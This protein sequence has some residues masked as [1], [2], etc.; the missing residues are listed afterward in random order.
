[1]NLFP[2]TLSSSNT[3]P[4][5]P[6]LPPLAPPNPSEANLIQRLFLQATDP[7]IPKEQRNRSFSELLDSCFPQN[8]NSALL[9]KIR[10]ASG[11]TLVTFAI[12]AKENEWTSRLIRY[13]S[14]CLEKDSQGNT[15][16]HQAAIRG[17]SSL[18]L[19]L[20]RINGLAEPNEQGET[21]LHLAIKHGHTEIILSLMEQ[22]LLPAE[23]LFLTEEYALN[24]L[25]Y[26]AFLGQTEIFAH[27]LTSSLFAK[28][29]WTQGLGNPLHVA[30]F[31]N[32]IHFPAYLQRQHPLLFQSWGD[33]QNELGLTPL[34]LAA[35]HGRD[36]C[37]LLLH[38]HFPRT[39]ELA[40]KKGKRPVFSAAL[41]LNHS[42]VKLIVIL[43]CKAEY[44]FAALDRLRETSQPEVIPMI[45]FMENLQ[46]LVNTPNRRE[47][48][49]AEPIRWLALAGGGQKGPGEIG[50]LIELEQL[51][52][53][54]EGISGT[55][56]GAI[57]GALLAVGYS[58]RELEKIFSESSFADLM[59]I[60]HLDGK[61]LSDLVSG[62]G[63]G[64]SLGSVFREIG[65]LVRRPL[66]HAFTRAQQTAELGQLVSNLFSLNG[67]FLGKKC[68]N[69]SKN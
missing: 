19:S 27:L 51:F 12:Q 2:S 17:D 37:I 52:P 31:G 56:I 36:R 35:L 61:Q 1:M 18:F 40:D 3:N 34:H 67:I 60:E 39:L 64:L 25:C 46:S 15:P 44:F 58:P 30:I 41:A 59:D 38:E 42:T 53:N 23:L 66:T 55:S 20:C 63:Q 10:T 62:T 29:Q 9:Q 8:E 48:F 26:A 21:A 69:G 50:A 45:H 47:A 7:A 57:N 33:Q 28:Q 43:G 13:P 11:D 68:E 14:L 54:I 65:Q 16:L 5:P 4:V 6:V 22:K 32:Q 49:K 24:L